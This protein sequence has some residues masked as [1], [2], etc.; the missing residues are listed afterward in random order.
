MGFGLVLIL[1]VV[2]NV[3]LSMCLSSPLFFYFIAVSLCYSFPYEASFSQL[4]IE[5]S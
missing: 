3:V 4:A 5:G 2:L 1:F